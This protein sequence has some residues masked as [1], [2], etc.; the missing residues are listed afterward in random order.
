MGLLLSAIVST[1]EKVMTLV[2]IAL[3]PQIMLAGAVAKIDNAFVEVLSYV[4]LSRW[5][6]EGFCNIQED[7]L[8]QRPDM[9]HF[10]PMNPTSDIPI[11]D[12]T[13]NSIQELEKSFH[14][15]YKSLFEDFAYT[16]KLDVIV[17]STLTILFFI[18]I[19]LA[20]KAKDS[21]K[22]K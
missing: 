7:V 16:L 5:G 22:I 19:Y 12:T 13:V 3:I 6:N 14:P 11:K 20:L 1:T 4:T 8:V 17:I 15:N 2:P 10:S 18:G 9:S 21:M